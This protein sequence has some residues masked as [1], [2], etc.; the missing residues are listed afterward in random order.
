MYEKNKRGYD[1]V[2]PPDNKGSP[3]YHAD[4][5]EFKYVLRGQGTFNLNEKKID[6]RSG[7][8]IFLSSGD[9]HFFE[10]KEEQETAFLEFWFPPPK[11][12]MW[13]NQRTWACES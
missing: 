13:L 5:Y 11:N 2:Y 3:H 4:A 8:I 7:Y 6:V 12:T 1:C 9:I 10:T